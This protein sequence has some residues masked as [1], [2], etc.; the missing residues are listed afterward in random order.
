MNSQKLRFTW[1]LHLSLITLPREYRWHNRCQLRSL[2]HSLHTYV[3]SSLSF[4]GRRGK[5]ALQTV[6]LRHAG[7]VTNLGLPTLE[8]CWMV[9]NLN[10]VWNA[11]KDL[12]S[13]DTLE[14]HI[15]HAK[16]PRE[17]VREI[18]SF[19]SATRCSWMPEQGLV[20]SSFTR[21]PCRRCSEEF[22]QHNL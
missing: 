5:P 1:S 10:S 16:V 22:Q 18:K 11:A 17:Y 8:S 6:K 19:C 20:I 12:V 4:R 7:K 3:R 2:S 9:F 14:Q 15:M 13:R 21:T